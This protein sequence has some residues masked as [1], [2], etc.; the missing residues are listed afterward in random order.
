M[1]ED[2]NVSLRDHFNEQ[3]KWVDKYFQ[4]QLETSQKAI[5]KAEQ[6]LNTRLESM[7]EFRDT[8]RD[9]ASQFTTRREFEILERRIALIERHESTGQG[10]SG[11]VTM[12]WAMGASVLTAVMVLVISKLF[13]K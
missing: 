3:I 4:K 8:L 9:Q 5:E 12:L 1:T 7:N 11:V 10:R 13:I 6:Q 2:H